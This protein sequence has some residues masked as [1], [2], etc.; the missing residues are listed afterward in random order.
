MH[1]FRNHYQALEMLLDEHC[2]ITV[3]AAI[4]MHLQSSHALSITYLLA[5]GLRQALDAT[6]TVHLQ[7]YTCI[8]DEFVGWGTLSEVRRGIWSTMAKT[9]CAF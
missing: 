4:H 6:E 2:C 3:I 5:C 8:M 1:A 7:L 9:L